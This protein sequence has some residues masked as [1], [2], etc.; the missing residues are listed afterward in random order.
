MVID[1]KY[2]HERILYEQYIGSLSTGQCITQKE[3]F[4]QAIELN[5]GD[6]NQLL[7]SHE[8]LSILGIE[9]SSLGHSTISINSLPANIKISDP[10]K[11]IEDILVSLKEN[12]S[13]PLSDAHHKLAASMAKAASIGYVRSLSRIEMQ[14]LV[15]KLFACQHPNY[16][17]D[18]KTILT[19]ISLD[20][21][22]KR[23]K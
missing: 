5:A 17:P 22:E 10:V 23:F 14:D 19:I 8:D 4:P 21:L 2:A 13:K 20:E 18:G 16:S 12:Q 1:Q 3:L 6:Y 7:S 15:D 11:F 9:I